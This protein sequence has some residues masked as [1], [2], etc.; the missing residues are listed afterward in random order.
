V[1]LQYFIDILL[2]DVYIRIVRCNKLG[3]RGVAQA[4]PPRPLPRLR[5]TAARQPSVRNIARVQLKEGSID[6]QTASPVARR[7]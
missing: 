5:F 1:S 3:I 6:E 2:A 4:R 7:P